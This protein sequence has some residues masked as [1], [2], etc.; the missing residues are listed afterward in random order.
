[1]ATGNDT[2]RAP[3]DP[4]RPSG[5]WLRQYNK[6]PNNNLPEGETILQQNIL[7]R[8]WQIPKP[9]NKSLNHDKKACKVS[10]VSGGPESPAM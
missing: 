7:L 2:P 3:G 6:N 9:L 8:F 4:S 10:G 1:M 5:H